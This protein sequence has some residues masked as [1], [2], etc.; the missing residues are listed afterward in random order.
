MHRWQSAMNDQSPQ[1]IAAHRANDDTLRLMLAMLLP[2]VEV[3]REYGLS[4]TFFLNVAL[5]CLGIFPGVM[6]A[7]FVLLYRLRSSDV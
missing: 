3:Y 6:H 1:A 4:K 2:P 7:V 5:T